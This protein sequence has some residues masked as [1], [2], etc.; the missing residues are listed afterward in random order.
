MME[1]LVGFL[2]TALVVSCL[3]VYN[4]EAQVARVPA[5]ARL[6]LYLLWTLSRSPLT[7]SSPI[8]KAPSYLRAR[9]RR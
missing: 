3:C 1:S 5:P 4:G 9:R 6:S 7:Q 8:T 2:L